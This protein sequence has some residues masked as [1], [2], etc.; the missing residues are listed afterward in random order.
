MVE[1]LQIY[2]INVVLQYCVHKN[3]EEKYFFV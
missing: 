1:F 3:R 2:F